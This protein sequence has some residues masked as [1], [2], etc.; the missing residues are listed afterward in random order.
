MTTM[1]ECPNC[2][3]PLR[4]WKSTNESRDGIVMWK[5][6]PRCGWHEQTELRDKIREELAN[7]DGREDDEFY[8]GA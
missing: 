6:C 2:K 5:H 3:G 1:V 8:S 4:E 7:G